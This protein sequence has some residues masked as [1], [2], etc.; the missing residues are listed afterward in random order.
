MNAVCLDPTGSASSVPID[1]HPAES[2]N[3]VPESCSQS[4]SIAEEAVPIEVDTASKIFI[5][6]KLKPTKVETTV[7]K[8]CA[9]DHNAEKSVPVCMFS[10]ENYGSVEIVA[11]L[12]QIIKLPY[13]LREIL[14]EHN[15]KP[16]IF[17]RRN[18]FDCTGGFFTDTLCSTLK[19]EVKSIQGILVDDGV[20]DRFKQSIQMALVYGRHRVAVI[21]QLAI[22]E[23]AYRWKTVGVHMPWLL[24]QTDN[25]W[26]FAR[27]SLMGVPEIL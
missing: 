4:I 21:Y 14:D 9:T 12:D 18:R 26:L 8:A 7:S 24:L 10:C 3:P 23:E 1:V 15:K 27:L 20:Y 22:Y 11:N 13:P 25:R 2:G 6:D 5:L 16:S 19:G 17:T